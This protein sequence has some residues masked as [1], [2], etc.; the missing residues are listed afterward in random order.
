MRA[1]RREWST[2][3][4][5]IPGAMLWKSETRRRPKLWQSA[6][7]VVD[8]LSDDAPLLCGCDEG[9]CFACAA[10]GR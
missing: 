8:G 9:G 4:G 2:A 6:L 3:G 10:G 1:T 5:G 7:R